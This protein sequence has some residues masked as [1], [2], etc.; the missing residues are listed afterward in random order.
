MRFIVQVAFGH[1]VD[2]DVRVVAA[3]YADSDT[4]D[5]SR[6]R[7]KLS[8]LSDDDLWTFDQFW[9]YVAGRANGKTLV[10]QIVNKTTAMLGKIVCHR[11]ADTCVLASY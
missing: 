5:E 6:R 7:T 9:D 1:W 2:E 4:N 11:G 10:A 3:L 8:Y